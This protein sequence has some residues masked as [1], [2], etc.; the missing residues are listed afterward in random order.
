M[1]Q[2]ENWPEVKRNSKRYQPT[3][4]YVINVELQTQGE[5]QIYLFSLL[6]IKKCTEQWSFTRHYFKYEGDSSG[7]VQ[8]PCFLGVYILMQETGHKQI[9]NRHTI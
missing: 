8:V 2:A 9:T 6:F 4:G 1:V 3:D 7:E 5:I